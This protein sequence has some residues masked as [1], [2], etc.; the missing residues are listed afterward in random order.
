MYL[1][2]SEQTSLEIWF[3]SGVQVPEL[4]PHLWGQGIPK[5]NHATQLKQCS[6]T[7]K[8][9]IL[10]KAWEHFGSSAVADL[11][12]EKKSGKVGIGCVILIIFYT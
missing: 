1:D 11:K 12:E 6:E 5:T 10:H 3:S 4:D 8:I 7:S 2:C 9:T